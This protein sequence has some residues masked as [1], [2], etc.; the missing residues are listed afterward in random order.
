MSNVVAEDITLLIGLDFMD[1]YA[2]QPLVIENA[3]ESVNEKWKIRLER[4]YGHL[5]MC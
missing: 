2:L 5:Y 4:K 1:R 3:L